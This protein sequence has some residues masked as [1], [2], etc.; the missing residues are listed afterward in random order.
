LQHQ[1]A[2]YAR[3][4]DDAAHEN[5]PSDLVDLR[6]LSADVWLAN[7]RIGDRAAGL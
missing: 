2:R 1:T 6:V 5:W 7:R 3:I 4:G